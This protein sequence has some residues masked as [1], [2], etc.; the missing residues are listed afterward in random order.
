MEKIKID[1]Q[2]FI[3]AKTQIFEP[4]KLKMKCAVCSKDS[5]SRCGSCKKIWY[6]S[7]ECQSQNWKHHK[8]NCDKLKMIQAKGVADVKEINDKADKTHVDFEIFQCQL[9]KIEEPY[10]Y[11]SQMMLHVLDQHKAIVCNVCCL[12]FNDMAKMTS[13]CESTGHN[14]LFQGTKDIMDNMVFT[15]TN[16]MEQVED[17]KC[18][19]CKVEKPLEC[20]YKN[21][22]CVS[23]NIMFEC[24]TMYRDHL[25]SGKCEYDK[26]EE[27]PICLDKLEVDTNGKV[28]Y[29][30]CTHQ[31]HESCCMKLYK[32]GPD[33]TSIT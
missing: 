29:L 18:N 6:C 21:Q 15:M 31:F 25:K 13:H 28:V 1:P 12:Q 22:S 16:N 9:C 14:N 24:K 26:Q 20:H 33:S 17:G 5:T 3:D 4:P 7:R 30:P 2:V 23:C 32:N 27:C 8:L 10:I 11:Y 19:F